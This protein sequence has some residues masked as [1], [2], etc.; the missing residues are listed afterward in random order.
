MSSDSRVSQGLPS[1]FNGVSQ[2]APSLRLPSQGEEQLNLFSS[3]VDGLAKRPYT[4][5]VAKLRNATAADAYIHIIDRD[6]TLVL[7]S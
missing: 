7:S 3:I 1:L 5:H 2:Q 4:E 6:Q